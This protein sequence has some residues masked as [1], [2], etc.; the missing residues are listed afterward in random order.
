MV[1]KGQRGLPRGAGSGAQRAESWE[2]STG[3]RV[4][5]RGLGSGRADWLLFLDGKLYDA[6]VSYSDCPED[7]K[8]VNFILKP[9][10]ERR[11]GYKLFLED[12][13]LLPRAGTAHPCSQR[14]AL[15]SRRPA[16]TTGPAS[17]P[18]RHLLRR[19]ALGPTP[20]FVEPPRPPAPPTPRRAP[21]LTPAR[22]RRALGRPPGEPEPVPA[23]DRGAFGRLPGPSLVQP[24]LPVRPVGSGWER[25]VPAEPDDGSAPP[26]R[27]CAGCWN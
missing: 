12:R 4:R 13:D 26:G 19:P 2:C 22:V 24:Q 1:R 18:V 17:L 6:F 14:P 11:R 5:D 25:A 15:G 8:F 20:A 3:T 10:L 21:P 9:Q 27:A 7:R 23:A 16:L